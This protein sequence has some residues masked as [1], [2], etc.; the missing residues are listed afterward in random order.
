MPTIRGYTQF[1]VKIGKNTLFSNQSILCVF[2]NSKKRQPR[3]GIVFFFIIYLDSAHNAIA[4]MD[5]GS[6][7]LTS[8][9]LTLDFSNILDVFNL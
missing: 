9:D 4:D 7:S 3:H 5:N 2:K 1:P 8:I 6:S